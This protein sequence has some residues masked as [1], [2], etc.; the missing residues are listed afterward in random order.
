M[1]RTAGE[2]GTRCDS[3]AANVI[4]LNLMHEIVG[5]RSVDEAQ[6]VYAETMAA[7]TMGRPTPY[8]ERLL[9]AVPQGGTEARRGEH[10]GGHGPTGGR[11][12]QGPGDGLRGGTGER[13]GAP[14][15]KT[16]DHTNVLQ[17]TRRHAC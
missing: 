1:D 10:G 7:Y 16:A 2:A 14:T 4:T 13:V 3:E 11:Q 6:Q 15:W 12:G 17:R 8:A 9:F 5:Q